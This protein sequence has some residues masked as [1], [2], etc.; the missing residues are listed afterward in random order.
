MTSAYKYAGVALRCSLAMGLHH[1]LPEGYMISP[2]E[3]E[4]RIRVWWSI[5][6]I[7]RVTSSKLGC[8]V[9]IRDVDIDV[10]L[11]SMEG[12]PPVE[13]EEFSDPGHLVAHVKLAGI[14]GAIISDIYGRPRQ[15][16]AI[17]QSVQ[18][19]LTDLQAWAK[20]LPGS[21]R[22]SM[23]GPYCSSQRNIASLHLCFNQVSLQYLPGEPP[24]KSREP[25]NFTGIVRMYVTPRLY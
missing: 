12:L 24:S 13:Q 19:I 23:A 7:D 3:R 9:T 22:F 11:P 16:K 10:D 15:Q 14:T 1:N 2:V 8:P 18:K 17:V 21:V 25:Q 4:H 6:I 20:A 5:Y